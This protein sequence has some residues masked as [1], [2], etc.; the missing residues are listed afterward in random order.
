MKPCL[1]DDELLHLLIADDGEYPDCR[2]H[3]LECSRCARRYH[4][5][6][7]DTGRVTSTLT[8][9]ADSLRARK[10]PSIARIRVR[11]GF[12]MA[13]IFSGA[14]AFGGGSAFIL[15]LALGWRPASA[16]IPVALN[17]SKAANS[18]KIGSEN[19]RL[20]Y[21]A[22]TAGS[23]TLHAAK[24]ITDD[25]I[26]GLVYSDSLTKAEANPEEDMLF[27]VPEDDGTICSRSAE[28][29]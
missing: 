16:Q 12:R 15:L 21:G 22:T 13:A 4:E 2:E 24:A 6:A 26:V 10:S 14:A 17:S 28:Q 5:A 11:D 9:A 7:L 1:Q 18:L 20:A 23:P 8:I 25:P 3:L 19:Q 27:C 29:G